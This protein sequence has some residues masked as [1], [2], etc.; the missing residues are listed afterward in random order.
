MIKRVYKAVTPPII[1]SQLKR[2]LQKGKGGFSG[3]YADWEMALNCS[4][5]YQDPDILEKIQQATL[6]V[7]N[8]NRLFIRDGLLFNEPQYSYPVLAALLKIALENNGRLRVL[9]VGGALGS[10]YYAFKRFCPQH[11][12]LS[13]DI[14]EQ[15]TFVECGN[16]TF[17]NT[18][19]AFYQDSSE[20]PQSPDVVLLS[21]TLQYL[22]TPYVF[23]SNLLQLQPSYL[24]L[25]RVSFN[26][27]TSINDQLVVEH[28]P[29]HIY[30]SSYPC[31]LF[32][33]QKMMNFLEQYFNI[34]FE[35]EAL[36]GSFTVNGF[37]IAS[38]G[39]FLRRKID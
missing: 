17:A 6:Q 8:D 23:L 1:Q 2:F 32:N 39:F 19:L 5:G 18:E 4:S 31:W 22:E 33:Y 38:K 25:D 7:R 34:E 11:L 21:A 26:A 20:L 36:E 13:W 24:L 35:C 28:V 12:K 9:D 10:S 27:G 15:K 3:P 14:V 16:A 30:K 37:A 29:Q